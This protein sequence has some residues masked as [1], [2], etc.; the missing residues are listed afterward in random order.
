MS[1]SQRHAVV[2]GSSA[3]IGAAI[4]QRLLDDGWRVTGIDRSPPSIQAEA[5]LSRIADIGEA[6]PRAQA[7]ARLGE[8][9]ALVHAAGAMRGGSLG[10]LDPADG[11]LL[12]RIHV[13]A[14]TALADKLVPGMA[15]GG[16]VVLIGS[17]AS[18]G[19]AHRSQYAAAK[20]ALV[21]LARS[22]ASEVVSRGIT[23]NVVAP[24][25]TDTGMLSDPSRAGVPP[26][27]PPIGRFIRPQEVAALVAFLL[28][29]EAGAITGQEI[30][31]C[32]GASL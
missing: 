10:A 24:A 9:D 6:G 19:V 14:A 4:T 16:R 1:S 31:V 27:L 17:R 32:G 3:G 30:M 23:V 15:R 18:Q 21:G 12:W 7:L 13:A 5:F 2:T 29:E 26:Q 20:A 11:D 25:A 22:W 8:V 28:S